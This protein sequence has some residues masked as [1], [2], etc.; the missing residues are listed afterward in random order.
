MFAAIRLALTGCR[1]GRRNSRSIIAADYHDFIDHDYWPLI[2]APA[3]FHNKR[4]RV[5]AC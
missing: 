5:A 2:V 4:T 3:H 1:R